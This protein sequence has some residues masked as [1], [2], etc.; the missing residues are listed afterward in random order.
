LFFEAICG[1]EGGE[2]NLKKGVDGISETGIPKNTIQSVA[3]Q[4]RTT[5]KLA[6]EEFSHKSLTPEALLPD[7]AASESG[8]GGSLGPSSYSKSPGPTGTSHHKLL[9]REQ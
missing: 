6:Y 5:K 4:R 3:T 9:F 7:I 2:K 1:G 8:P